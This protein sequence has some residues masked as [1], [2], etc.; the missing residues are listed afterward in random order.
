M[1]KA[2][3]LT[4]RIAETLDFD[5]IHK[6]E[7][8]LDKATL[9]KKITDGKVYVVYSGDEFV[10][11]LRYGLFWDNIPFMNMLNLLESHQRKGIGRK[12]VEFWEAEMCK[13]GYK[14][15]LTSAPSNEHAQH[16]YTKL[17]YKAIG[18]FSLKNDPLEIMFQKII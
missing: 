16:F 4:I 7:K 15:V 10:G 9:S 1:N 11:W 12:L 17:G 8:W 6:H 2:R 18:S 3:N 14:L 5:V 13:K